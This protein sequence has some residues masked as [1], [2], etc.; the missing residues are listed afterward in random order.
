M[1]TGVCSLRAAVS[2]TTMFLAVAAFAAAAG[3]W[4]EN[5]SPTDKSFTATGRNPFWI[6]EPGYQL[7]LEGKEDGKKV[8]LTITALNETKKIDGVETRV[9]EERETEDGKLAEVSRNYFAIGTETHSLYYFGEDV[10]VFKGDKVVHEGSWQ[11]GRDGAKFGIMIPGEIK[12]GSR[13]Y[14]ER[15]E[16]VAMDR[17]ENVSGR[18]SLKTPAGKFTNCLKTR[19]TSPLEPDHTEYKVFAPGIGIV[20]DDTLKLVSYGFAGK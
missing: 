10:D 6:L 4:Q 7:N 14:Q 20:Q 13:Y 17:A 3:D 2:V 19:E 8:H 15:A 18:F 5:L 11:S 1:K 16:G 12:A 9:V